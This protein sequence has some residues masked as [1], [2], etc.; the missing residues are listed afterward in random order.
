MPAQSTEIID[1][2]T[3][4]AR[5]PDGARIALPPDYSGCAMAAVRAD[6][7]SVV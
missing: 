5:I 7:K 3:L 1:L 4:A 6:R 2:E